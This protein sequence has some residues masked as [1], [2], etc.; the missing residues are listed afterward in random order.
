MSEFRP[1]SLT[2]VVSKMLESIVR[3][4]LNAVS[5][6]QQWIPPYQAG[7]RPRRCAHEH[8]V[9]LQLA[10]H[11]AFKRR[12]VLLAAFLDLSKAYDTVSRP[13]LLYKLKHLGV[14]GPMLKFLSSFLGRRLSSVIYRSSESDL[15]E[16]KNGVPQGSPLSPFLFILYIAQALSL[17]EATR[18]VRLPTTSHSGCLLQR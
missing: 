8:L 12:E 7:F 6:R 10:G 15:V 2:P 9:R 11:T 1:I 18:C 4:R 16:F 13:L 5:E 14:D 3:E 17:T